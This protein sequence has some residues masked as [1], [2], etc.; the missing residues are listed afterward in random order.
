MFA[1]LHAD[2]AWREKGAGEG[3]ERQRKAILPHSEQQQAPTGFQ[4]LTLINSPIPFSATKK[5]I[6]I[7]R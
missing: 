3:G 4:H 5:G 2:T 6:D 7:S 1:T